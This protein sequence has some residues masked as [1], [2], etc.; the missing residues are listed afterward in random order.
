[1]TY[2]CFRLG[3]DGFTENRGICF[4]KFKFYSKNWIKI[5]EPRML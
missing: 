2:G 4:Q 3:L 5:E 1:M